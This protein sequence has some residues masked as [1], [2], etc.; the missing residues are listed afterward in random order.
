MEASEVP[1]HCQIYALSDP[2][3][4]EFRGSCDH[5]HSESDRSCIGEY[6]PDYMLFPC[7]EEGCVKA[8]SRFAN[9]QTHLDTGKH[10]MM[11]EQETLYD[12]A[13]RE[14]SSKLTEGRSRIPSVQVAAQSKSDGLPPLPMGWALK[15]IKKKVRFT[16]KQTEFLTDQFQKGEYSGRKSDPQEK[17]KP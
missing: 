1:D 13:K 2:S 5:L 12:K 8:Y 6:K 15:K 17:R 9:L 7:P 11:L 3:N 10:Q 4:V 14:Y 16:K